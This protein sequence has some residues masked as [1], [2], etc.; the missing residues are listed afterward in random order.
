[1][2]LQSQSQAEQ[3]VTERADQPQSTARRVARAARALDWRDFALYIGFAAVFVVFA[4][5]LH[6]DGFLT[7]TNLLNIVRQT[8]IIAVM[9]VA[10][11]FVIAAAQIDLSVGSVAGLSSVVAA[12]TVSTTESPLM[13]ALAGLGTGLVVGIINGSIV[14]L[15]GVPSF[16]VTLAMLGIAVGVAQW[17]SDFQPIPITDIAFTNAFGGGNLGPFPTLMLWVIGITFVGVVLM[18]KTSFGRQALAT[19]GNPVAAAYSGIR[20]KRI[21]FTVLVMSGVAA[22]LAGLLYAGRLHSGRFQWGV[23][24]ELSVIAAVVLGGTALFGGT[25][26]VIGSAIGALFVGLI[27]NG[28]VLAGLDVSQQVI[29]QG[30][31]IIVAVALAKKK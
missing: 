22:G 6:D 15:L 28:L 21:T 23:G 16:L 30:V 24:D 7:N 11:T 8:A 31:I 19:G 18:N 4:I 25:G 27:N 13:G 2:T 9:A 20:T 3:P 10:V 26:R 14:T 5:F 12:M 29:I 17:I 1:M